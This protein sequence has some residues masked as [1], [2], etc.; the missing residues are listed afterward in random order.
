MPV[1]LNRQ[2]IKCIECGGVP[3]I[4]KGRYRNLCPVCHVIRFFEE[5]CKHTK[6]KWAGTPFHL[7]DWQ[8]EEVIKPLFGTLKPDGTRQYRIC[9]VEIPKKN[10]KTEFGGG[11]G[12]YG[13]IG[14]DEPGAEVYSAA[15]NRDGDIAFGGHFEGPNEQ[16]AETDWPFRDGYYAWTIPL[17]TPRN[18]EMQSSHSRRKA[19]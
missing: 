8:V 16:F 19:A 1:F 10:G 14:D 9:Y 5:R 2:Q 12:I 6:A 13:L 4:L 18:R 11:I 7:L 15:G 3:K 17:R